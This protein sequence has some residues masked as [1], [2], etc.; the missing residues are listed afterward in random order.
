[1][2]IVSRARV[3]AE[4]LG[5]A[6]SVCIVCT[7]SASFTSSTRM[8]R[9]IATSILRKLSAWLCCWLLNLTLE[10]VASAID[11]AR[12][13]LPKP[14]AELVH[15]LGRRRRRVVQERRGE[16]GVVEPQ[17]RDDVG[18]GQRMREVGLGRRPSLAP[19]LLP[20]EVERPL[21]EP[22]IYPGVIGMCPLEETRER[23][24]FPR[25]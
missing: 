2:S 24:L 20:R 16:A 5:S 25:R 7:R 6:A 3:R 12:D 1:M 10:R 8:S 11:E 23:G 14:L 21:Q 17:P 9:A 13:G 4:S 18:H 22:L 15:G 19:L